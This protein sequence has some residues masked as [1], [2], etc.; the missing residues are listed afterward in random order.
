L[1]ERDSTH[2]LIRYWP[3]TIAW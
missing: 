2:K 1:Q 3:S